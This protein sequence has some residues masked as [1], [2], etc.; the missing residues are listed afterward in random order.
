MTFQFSATSFAEPSEDDPTA[1]YVDL[2]L[3]SVCDVYEKHE[4]PGS[5]RARREGGRRCRSE[6]LG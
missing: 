2:I 5:P 6:N 3:G 4:A 1:V